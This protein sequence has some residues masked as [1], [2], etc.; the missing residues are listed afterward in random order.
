MK[1]FSI[2]LLVYSHYTL[3]A[4]DDGVVLNVAVAA[5]CRAPFLL[6]RDHFEDQ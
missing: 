4:S 5:N 2:L 3:A 1:F 6:V